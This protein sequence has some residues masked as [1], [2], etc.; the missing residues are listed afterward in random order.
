MT[1]QYIGKILLTDEWADMNSD[2]LQFEIPDGVEPFEFFTHI[3]PPDTKYLVT[4]Y[5]IKE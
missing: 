3:V 5:E 4:Y 2:L 1:V